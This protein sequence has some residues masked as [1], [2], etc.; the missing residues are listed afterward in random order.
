MI[1]HRSHWEDTAGKAPIGLGLL[2]HCAHICRVSLVDFYW[3]IRIQHPTLTTAVPHEKIVD[4]TGWWGGLFL[5]T[6][7]YVCKTC[8]RLCNSRSFKFII[9]TIMYQNM[10]FQGPKFQKKFLGRGHS[11]CWK[12]R[13]TS[14]IANKQCLVGRRP[15]I[16]YNPALLSHTTLY[17]K[18]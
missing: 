16:C 7:M 13:C 17:R 3:R 6:V 11:P 12:I 15:C 14:V 9:G 5:E 4:Q 8:F 10:P 2:G 1:C 18:A